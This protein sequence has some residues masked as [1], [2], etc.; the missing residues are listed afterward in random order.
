MLVILILINV[1]HFIHIF[2][3]IIELVLILLCQST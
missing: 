2:N 1:S 3:G